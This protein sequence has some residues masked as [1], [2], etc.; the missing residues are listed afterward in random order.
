MLFYILSA[1]AGAVAMYFGQKI[2]AKAEVKLGA[3]LTKVGQD[4]A[5]K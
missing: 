4:L 5:P 2:V 3:E 1:V